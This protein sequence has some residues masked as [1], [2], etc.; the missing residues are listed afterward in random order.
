MS[1]NESFVPTVLLADDDPATLRLLRTIVSAAGYPVLEAR[2]GHE[3][4]EKI[5]AENP[6]LVV[7]DWEMP[8]MTGPALCEA[9]RQAKLPKYVYVMLL[10]ARTAD[11]EAIEGL[12]A[13]A[14]DF[15]SKPIKP[16]ILRARL[17]AGTRVLAME[18]RLLEVSQHDSLTGVLNRRTFH[19]RCVQEWG[20]ADRYSHPLAC[21]MVDLDF[22]KKVNDTHG[23]AAGDA[24]LRV[25]AAVLQGHCRSTDVICRYGGEEFCVLLPE[26][27]EIGAAAWAERARA[28]LAQT[29]VPV[30][31]HVMRVTGS[32]GVAQSLVD[33]KG[34]D[35]LIELA[36]QALAVA[37]QS[38][39][40]RVTRFSALKDC[41]GTIGDQGTLHSPLHGMCARDVMMP[42]LLCPSEED[43]LA[44][45]S[46]LL[47]GLRLTSVPV[48][49][50]NG[51]LAGIVSEMDLAQA[52][53][54]GNGW[55][56]PVRE[57]MKTDVVTFEEDTS[58]RRVLD[59]LCRAAIRRVVIVEGG[60]PSGVISR[61]CIL[62]WLRNWYLLHNGTAAI[63]VIQQAIVSMDER[64]NNIL[65]IVE[66]AEQ[67]LS[68]LRTK[69]GD[70]TTDHV[71]A[72]V[73]EVSRL[74]E[75]ANDLLG[76]S[77]N[78]GEF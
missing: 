39:R 23:H 5:L 11:A 75:M 78:G 18:R 6:D 68:G 54:Q 50:T 1:T 28:D 34:P 17:R 14:D 8:G 61:G 2:D 13:G 77:G 66:A 4:Y 7:S 65:R 41:A 47:L 44:Q 73:A 56:R 45:I 20:R 29:A 51:Q 37:K 49:H 63:P 69:I 21:V 42:A 30:G 67:R 15:I 71:P 72:L 59:F 76:H 74:Q 57:I 38:G 9:I 12:E 32:F 62:R 58:A 52:T 60:R 64:R 70:E 22:F 36:D 10:T 48:V 33:T 31:G 16:A 24:V 35:A 46:D 40:N 3:A 55:D 26:T 43:T 19:E 53:A 25:A 27:N